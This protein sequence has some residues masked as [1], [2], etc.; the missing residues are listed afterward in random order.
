V[1]DQWK[2]VRGEYLHPLGGCASCPKGKFGVDEGCATCPIGYISSNNGAPWCKL[3]R[4]VAPFFQ[5]TPS[6]EPLSPPAAW[7]FSSQHQA[8]TSVTQA[9]NQELFM[10]Q[11]SFP[12]L[13]AQLGRLL[14]YTRRLNFERG[15]LGETCRNPASSALGVIFRR[16][17]DSHRVFFALQACTRWELVSPAAQAAPQARY[18]MGPR[19]SRTCECR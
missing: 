15:C 14:E 19:G 6:Y 16:W 17:Q 7:A 18:F 11:P 13:L 12:V 10:I 9:V 1:V 4:C 5:C 2:C 8:R 3:C